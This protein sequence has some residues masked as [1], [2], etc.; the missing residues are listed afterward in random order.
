ML[1]KP[2]AYDKT[3][4]S[5]RK[6]MQH[7]PDWIQHYSLIPVLLINYQDTNINAKPMQNY[8]KKR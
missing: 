2:I 6:V 5:V 1:T 7:F 8:E 3:L 4:K